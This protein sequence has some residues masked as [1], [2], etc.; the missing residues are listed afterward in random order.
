MPKHIEHF[1]Q[2]L[3]YQHNYDAL[4][5][6]A[7]RSLFRDRLA[8]ALLQAARNSRLVAVL[9]LDLDRFKA[10]NERL[11]HGAGDALLKH[12]ATCLSGVPRQ[13]D[14]VARLSSD[15][16]VVIMSDVAKETDV[17]PIARKL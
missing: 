13:G 6:L 2:A 3:D 4:T 1:E 7:N 17:A 8:Q 14:T 5:G 11:G 10:I 16:F 15:E 12:V 9:V